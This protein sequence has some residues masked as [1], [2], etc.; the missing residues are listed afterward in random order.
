MKRILLLL[1]LSLAIAAVVSFVNDSVI[2]STPA[3]KVSEVGVLAIPIFIVVCLLYYINKSLIKKI[4]IK[5]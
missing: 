1:I 5:K 3:D 2:E 4:R